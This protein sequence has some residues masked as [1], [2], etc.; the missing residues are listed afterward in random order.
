M[1]HGNKLYF[2]LELQ[3]GGLGLGAEGMVWWSSDGS[4]AGW[5]CGALIG[6]R[7]RKPCQVMVGMT[8]TTPLGIVPLLGDVVLAL[9]P[10]STTNPPRA[11]VVSHPN[12]APPYNST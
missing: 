11:T 1:A 2:Q 12:P 3:S 8:K 6:N 9:T 5:L 10:P 4:C 7:S